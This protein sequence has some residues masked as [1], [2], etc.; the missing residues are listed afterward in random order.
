MPVLIDS[1]GRHG[2]SIL[3]SPGNSSVKCY[4]VWQYRSTMLLRILCIIR[5]LN[6]IFL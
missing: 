1:H 5:S 6:M 2:K 4:V 3:M